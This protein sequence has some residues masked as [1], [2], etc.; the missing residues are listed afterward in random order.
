ME[1]PS[2]IQDILEYTRLK[3]KYRKKHKELIETFGFKNI[4]K[5][6]MY[7]L[8]NLLKNF[9]NNGSKKTCRLCGKK[10]HIDLDEDICPT[11]QVIK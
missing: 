9:D 1:Y 4:N 6:Q 11:C 8:L 5:K 3:K 10:F 7:I 2:D